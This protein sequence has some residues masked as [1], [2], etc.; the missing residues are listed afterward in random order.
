MLSNQTTVQASKAWQSKQENPVD[1]QTQTQ[2]TITAVALQHLGE[3]P[4]R[5]AQILQSFQAGE[6]PPANSEE[7]HAIVR[8][9]SEKA[10]GAWGYAEGS[11]AIWKKNGIEALTL[12]DERYPKRLRDLQSGPAPSLSGE[13]DD[14]CPILYVQGDPAA[15][16]GE[17]AAAIV[18]SRKAGEDTL[19]KAHAFGKELAEQGVTVV[20]GLA[21]GCDTQ[22]HEGCLDG[23]GRTVAVLAVLPVTLGRVWPPQNANLAKRILDSGGCLVSEYPPGKRIQW[24]VELARRDRIQSALSDCVAVMETSPTGG[25]MH[26]ARFAQDQERPLSVLD[27]PGSEGNRMLLA[28]GAKHLQEP[29]DLLETLDTQ[30]QQSREALEPSLINQAAAIAQPQDPVIVDPRIMPVPEEAISQFI[31]SA[32]GKKRAGAA[33][34][35]QDYSEWTPE[36]E[37]N[38]GEARHRLGEHPSHLFRNILAAADHAAA[39]LAKEP[40]FASHAPERKQL[41]ALA[42]I[43]LVEPQDGPSEVQAVREALVT[44]GFPLERLSDPEASVEALTRL[45]KACRSA[46][47]A[48]KHVRLDE[49]ALRRIRN[50]VMDYVEGQAAV[51][52][53]GTSPLY[54]HL[55][56]RARKA[57]KLA[58]DGKNLSEVRIRPAQPMHLIHLSSRMPHRNREDL[59]RHAADVAETL[60]NLHK[61]R[62]AVAL[63]RPEQEEA[64]RNHLS[65]EEVSFEV[66]YTGW[67]Q[68]DKKPCASMSH[69]EMDRKMAEGTVLLIRPGKRA[70]QHY[71]ESENTRNAWADQDV[72]WEGPERNV[73]RGQ[74]DPDPWAVSSMWA[75]GVPGGPQ[76]VEIHSSFSKSPVSESMDVRDFRHGYA[77][78]AVDVGQAI[79]AH[80][81][82]AE[83][84][85]KRTRI[86]NDRS[87]K[88]DEEPEKEIFEKPVYLTQAMNVLRR[89]YPQYRQTDPRISPDDRSWELGREANQAW[90]LQQLRE[91]PNVIHLES[92]SRDVHVVRKPSSPP[93]AADPAP[94]PAQAPA[95]A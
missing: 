19:K 46:E 87:R 76:K 42:K 40:F 53:P 66:V 65:R 57:V 32:I 55:P 44:N 61:A 92:S 35:A 14:Y 28:Q 6:K 12:L 94:E 62:R 90:A 77:A 13:A 63:A 25:T 80:R 10:I 79:A 1:P 29:R 88:A 83:C 52:T 81:S 89:A 16:Q 2:A 78:N 72:E 68:K 75:Y 5:I 47:Q 31:V 9:G 82:G 4:K 59:N 95:Q 64:L 20:S 7:F 85:M 24:K 30:Q 26:T 91:N 34:L 33:R 36:T 74:Q 17:R 23:G 18:G 50:S 39:A 43:H 56:E 8:T 22:G 27:V 38:L 41:A 11:L 58:L 48:E 21:E 54:E 67:D 15:L 71:N 3:S 70:M 84:T 45:S 51:A 69:E 93:P 37:R 49:D 60:S 73:F 86:R